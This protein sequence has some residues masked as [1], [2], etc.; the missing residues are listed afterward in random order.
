MK[1]GENPWSALASQ[2][3]LSPRESKALMLAPDG[4]TEYWLLQQSAVSSAHHHES[5]RGILLQ[6]VSFFLLVVLAIVVGAT[7][8]S[9]F[10]VLCELISG[11]T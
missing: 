9:F 11:L 3:L 5:V 7:A 2:N 1:N 6:S 4:S 8:I 10:M